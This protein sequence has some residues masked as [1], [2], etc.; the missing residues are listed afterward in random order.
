M[1]PNYTGKDSP[2]EP[3]RYLAGHEWRDGNPWSIFASRA[4]GGQKQNAGSTCHDLISDFDFS[5]APEALSLRWTAHDPGQE[6]RCLYGVNRAA[7]WNDFLASL[8]FQ[9]APT[10]NYVYADRQGNIGYS[11][12]GKIPI[13]PAVPSLLPL[14][15]WEPSNEW[16]GWIPFS[17]LPRLYNPPEGIIATANNRIADGAYPHYLSHFFD[18]PYR[19]RRIRELLAAKQ[20]HSANDMAA[21]QMDLTSFHARELIDSLRTD[22]TWIQENDLTLKAAAD[23]L[24]RWDGKCD[25][26]SFPSVVSTYSTTD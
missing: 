12:A 21:I 9:I 15:G 2:A 16:R 1:M 5:P 10:L 26:D 8:A 19:I 20:T 11:L 22:L 7:N 25:E 23:A 24:L 3:D 13:R 18:P 4:R 14:E 17:E 6:F